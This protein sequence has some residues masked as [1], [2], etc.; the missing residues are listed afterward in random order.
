MTFLVRELK[1]PRDRNDRRDVAIKFPFRPH[2]S[3][4]LKRSPE[5]HTPLRDAA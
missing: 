1:V 4:A 5:C 3:G 2:L